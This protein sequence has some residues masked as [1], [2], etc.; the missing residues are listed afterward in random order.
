[1]STFSAL[2][3]CAISSSIGDDAAARFLNALDGPVAEA[4]DARVLRQP[5]AVAKPRPSLARMEAIVTFLILLR[6]LTSTK[7]GDL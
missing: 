5:A 1:V 3:S 6:S 4:E 2:R 7:R